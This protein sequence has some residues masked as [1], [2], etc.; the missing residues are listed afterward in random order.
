MA[1]KKLPDPAFS[2]PHAI[3][4][5][6]KPFIIG[7]K[8]QL[9]RYI[10]AN[11]IANKYRTSDAHHKCIYEASALFEHLTTVATYMHNAD[12]KLPIHSSI[13]DFRNHIR[14]DARGEIDERSDERAKRLGLLKN[15]LV[16]IEFPDSAIKIGTITLTVSQISEY[17]DIA[18]TALYSLVLGAEIK[19]TD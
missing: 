3:A 15:L 6:V 14:H 4:M 8:V 11:E 13:R 16:G 12:I 19:V 10:K 17:L 7:S 2:S 18:E 5:Q 9:E 1:K